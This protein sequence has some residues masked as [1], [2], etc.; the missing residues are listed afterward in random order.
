[1]KTTASIPKETLI[2]LLKLRKEMLISPDDDKFSLGKLA[3]DT[4]NKEYGFIIGPIT[5][6]KDTKEG[7]DVKR[8]LLVTLGDEGPRVRYTRLNKIKTFNDTEEGVDDL[9][10]VIRTDVSEF[11]NNLCI[12]DCSNNCVLFKYKNNENFNK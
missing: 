7:V 9:N 12:H 1:M 5:L 11:C 8:A 4:S 3:F 2:K 6:D 10:R